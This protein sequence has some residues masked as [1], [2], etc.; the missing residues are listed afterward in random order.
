MCIAVSMASNLHT[1]YMY[2][3]RWIQLCKCNRMHACACECPYIN[4]RKKRDFEEIH[5]E[6]V[7]H[8]HHDVKDQMK[9]VLLGHFV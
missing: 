6:G 7:M 1:F 3:V 5:T 9:Y 2:G 4:K 8:V